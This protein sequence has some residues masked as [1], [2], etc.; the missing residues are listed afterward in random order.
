MLTNEQKQELIKVLNAK[1][2]ALQCPICQA[3]A[4]I[5]GDGYFNNPIQTDFSSINIGGPSIPS[6]PL[7]CSNC[8]FISQHALG[9]IGKLPNKNENSNESTK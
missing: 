2:P 9:A 1:V 8:G 6:I 3:R 5:M 7:I 4:F